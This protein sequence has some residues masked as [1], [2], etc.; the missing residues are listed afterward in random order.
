MFYI[1]IFQ[2]LFGDEKGVRKLFSLLP[3]GKQ[4]EILRQIPLHLLANYNQRELFRDLFNFL[5]VFAI[6]EN[7]LSEEDY[8]ENVGLS[9]NEE[10]FPYRSYKD[11]MENK[12]KIIFGL[13]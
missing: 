10:E 1:L 2:K 9:K 4:R 12:A 8:Q 5:R 3:G 13:T 7:L 6:D 11:Y